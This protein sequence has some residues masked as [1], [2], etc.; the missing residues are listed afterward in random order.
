MSILAFRLRLVNKK[1]TKKIF[2]YHID[3]I[4]CLKKILKLLIIEDR[5]V[6]A[7]LKNSINFA[8]ITA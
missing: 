6:I 8:G 4:R 5:W 2:L 1:M 3:L 7:V